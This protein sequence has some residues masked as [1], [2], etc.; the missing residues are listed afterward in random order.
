MRPDL[1]LTTSVLAAWNGLSYSSGYFNVSDGSLLV[2]LSGPIAWDVDVA[3]VEDMVSDRA[4]RVL[5]P[6]FAKLGYVYESDLKKRMTLV[7]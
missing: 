1:Y 5:C 7:P 6:E 2:V 4:I 3:G